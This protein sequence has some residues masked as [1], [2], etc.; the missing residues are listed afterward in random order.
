[1]KRIL[2]SPKAVRVAAWLHHSASP[3]QVISDVALG[4]IVGL[5]ADTVLRALK[6]LSELGALT[7]TR[8]GDH[9]PR[10]ITVLPACWIWSALAQ[11]VAL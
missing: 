6:E 1:M 3:T 11:G 10:T 8:A 4:S 2:V 7:Y 5:E 9:D